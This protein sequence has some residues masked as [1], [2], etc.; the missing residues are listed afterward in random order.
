VERWR[1][2]YSHGGFEKGHGATIYLHTPGVGAVPVGLTG[3]RSS[4]LFSFIH[5]TETD[6]ADV[7]ARFGEIDG[8]LESELPHAMQWIR[9][10]LAVR[11]DEE[12]RRQAEAALQAG[13]FQEFLHSHGYGKTSSTTWTTDEP[14]TRQRGDLRPPDGNGDVRAVPRPAIWASANCLTT[15]SRWL[16]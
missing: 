4:P 13:E 7:F 16:S 1:N 10:G 8:W 15:S 5:A 14:S 6:I 3:A 12:F 9:S 2:P 11:F